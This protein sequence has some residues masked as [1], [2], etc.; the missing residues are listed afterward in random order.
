MSQIWCP[1]GSGD[2]PGRVPG[3]LTPWGQG[4][5]GP[6]PMGSGS[7]DPFRDP[8]GLDMPQMTLLLDQKGSKRGPK[9][10][11]KG[12]KND[13]FLVTFGTPF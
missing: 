1:Q 9:S 3:V 10:D 6:D 7:R 5:G 13:P 8:L 4:P 11:Q 12:A 2:P